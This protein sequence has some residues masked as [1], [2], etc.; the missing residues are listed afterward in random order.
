MKIALSEAT[1]QVESGIL[2]KLV[3]RGCTVTV[4]VYWK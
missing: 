2:E 3:C 1:G 4:V